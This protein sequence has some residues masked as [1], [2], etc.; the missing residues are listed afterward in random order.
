M[1]PGLADWIKILLAFALSLVIAFLMT[2]PV[3]RFAEKV[4]AIDVP[5]D[6]RRVHNHPIPRMGGLA[7]FMGFVLS[8]IV[9]VPMSTKV[10]GLLVGALIIAVMGGVDDIVCLNPWIKLL[11][12]VI[13][14]LVAIRCGLVF[15]VIS[16]PNIFAE[17]T[18]IEIGYLSIPLTMLWIVA[19]T[20]AVN[21]IDGLDGL[22][23]GV[24]AISS[25]T[26]LIVSLFVSEPVVSLILAALTG[27]CLGFMPYNLNPA[28]IFMGD[29]GSQLLGFVLS[30]ASIMGLFK[31]HAIIT[32]FVPLLA[33]AL[34]LADTIFAFFRRILH[35]Q[36]PFK[37]DK[38]H[39]HHRLLAMGLN[40]KQVV[41][42]LYGISA[43]LGLL[44]V[45]MA[46]NSVAVKIICLVTAFIISLVIWLKIFKNNP[47][48]RAEH[49]AVHE[50]IQSASAS[51]DAG[52]LNKK[53]P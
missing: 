21:L 41:A 30:T 42:V 32:F 1:F 46:G 52:S 12:Q 37:A 10:L 36:S 23:V 20:N 14:A 26:M 49:H 4:G 15:D 44:A 18:Y 33:L 25:L 7:I 51:D 24:S 16:N 9:F 35:G 40:Q 50:H 3:K 27:A 39:F 34:P 22:A 48:L 8:L 2:P 45:L 47:N 53:T 11:G 5:K 13:A 38:G 28:K 17:E 6:D 43:V 29:V 31:L 19:C